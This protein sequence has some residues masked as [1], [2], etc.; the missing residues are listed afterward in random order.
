MKK[1]KI[2]NE[3]KDLFSVILRCVLIGLI[4]SI[5]FF[6]WVG[7]YQAGRLSVYRDLVE[8]TDCETIYEDLMSINVFDHKNKGKI[9]FMISNIE[10]N[11]PIQYYE[12]LKNNLKNN[13]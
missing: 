7:F 8:Y 13:T 10:K 1:F 11:C 3:H 6:H 2:D 4:T 9:D 5:T 12:I